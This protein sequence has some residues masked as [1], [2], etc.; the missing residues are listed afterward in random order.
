MNDFKKR[1]LEE[2]NELELK[3]GKLSNFLKKNDDDGID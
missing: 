3:L 1:I 2:K